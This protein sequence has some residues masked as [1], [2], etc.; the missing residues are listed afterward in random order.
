MKHLNAIIVL[1]VILLLL[2]TFIPSIINKIGDS[3]YERMQHY[4]DSLVV[5]ND[6][7]RKQVS[8]LDSADNRISN[9]TKAVDKQIVYIKI[10]SN[11]SIRAITNYSNIKLYEFFSNRTY[12]KAD[13]SARGI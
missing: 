3:K 10:K 7:I 1:I 5:L 12:I 8:I 4:I 6:S 9:E 11:E 13:S 2:A